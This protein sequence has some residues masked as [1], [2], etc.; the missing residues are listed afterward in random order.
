MQID[1]PREPPITGQLSSAISLIAC[2]ACFG[3][4][5]CRSYRRLRP[6]P[7]EARRSGRRLR[8]DVVGDQ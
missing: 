7:R 3:A 8:G 4:I 5:L 2:A 6:A 1:G